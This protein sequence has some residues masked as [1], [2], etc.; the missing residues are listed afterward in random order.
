MNN[1]FLVD[2]I[3]HY[4]NF[5]IY[6]RS[7]LGSII[8]PNQRLNVHHQKMRITATIKIM[9]CEIHSPILLWKYSS[10]L[11]RENLTLP[12]CIILLKFFTYYL[13]LTCHFFSYTL[14]QPVK[15]RCGSTL[16]LRAFFSL[17]SVHMWLTKIILPKLALTALTLPPVNRGPMSTM[18][19]SFS[20]KFCTLSAFLSSLVCI[21]RSCLSRKQELS[22]SVKISSKAPAAPRT[23]PSI[24]SAQHK[25]GSVSVP[26][27]IRP[28]G[29][30]YWRSSCSTKSDT[31]L[32][33]ISLHMHFPSLSLETIPG[34]TAISWP[35]FNT[36][37]RILPQATLTARFADLKGFNNSK[38]GFWSKVS[39]GY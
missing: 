10:R 35:T 20:D 30:A 38:S 34:L 24:P 12:Q 5:Y 15:H 9:R 18:S 32:E 3:Q 27:P 22:N 2:S 28:P 23:Y 17:N 16:R 31:I 14:P 4:T 21:P 26:A 39:C 25:V 11:L 37:F 33:K 7:Y 29:A 1:W 8:D 36:P 6:Y 19:T 13:L